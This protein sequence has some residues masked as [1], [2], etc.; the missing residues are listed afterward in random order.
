M[1][2]RTRF[3]RRR[4]LRRK[5]SRSSFRTRSHAISMAGGRRIPAFKT[6]IRRKAARTAPT[7]LARSR[8]TPLIPKTRSMSLVYRTGNREVDVS[9]LT[10][11]TYAYA[12]SC[13]D[14][15]DPDITGGGHSPFQYNEA[16]ALYGAEKVVSSAITIT[17]MNRSILDCY[18][19]ISLQPAEE[20]QYSAT[21][22]MEKPRVV[23]ALLPAKAVDGRP[24]RKTL[25][26][27]FNLAR[28]SS[29]ANGSFLAA[30]TDSDKVTSYW[31]K[32]GTTISTE[33]EWTF[34]ALVFFPSWVS[35]TVATIVDVPM[36][37]QIKYNVKFSQPKEVPTS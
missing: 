17:F 32:T 33:R 35:P 21:E 19:A 5:G 12:W 29:G 25:T 37:V 10:N 36:D 4:V 11:T 6:R 23:Y 14:L 26:L 2:A 34:R 1:A 31:N 3:T 30:Q 8:S 13:Q 22:V 18:V 16:T 28:A 9:V 27:S 7:S 15:L 20:T 24:T